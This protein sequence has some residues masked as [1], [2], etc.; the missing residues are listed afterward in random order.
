MRFPALH[1]GEAYVKVVLELSGKRDFFEKID[2]LFLYQW[3]RSKL[4]D[5]GT[6]QQLKNHVDIVKALSGV[7]G[8]EDDIKAGTRYISPAKVIELVL[9]SGIR[10]LDAANLRNKLPLFS[11]AE[12]LYRYLRCDAVHNADFPFINESIDTKGNISYENNHVITG[13]V[14]LE[15]VESVLKTMWKE[16]LEKEKWPHE[17]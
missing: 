16:C 2:L 11:L 14:L 13:D 9:A 5:N 1:D 4:S 15:T 12:L 17:L 10:G 7:Y 6:Y 8:S 3:P